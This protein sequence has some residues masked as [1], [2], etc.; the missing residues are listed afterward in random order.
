MSFSVN[1]SSAILRLK[2]DFFVELHAP[3]FI[4]PTLLFLS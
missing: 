3:A 4:G 1:I 2:K